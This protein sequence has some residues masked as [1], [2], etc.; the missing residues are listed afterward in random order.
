M[1]ILQ[2]CSGRAVNGAVIHCWALSQRLRALGH[3]VVIAC[4]EQS[5]IR[6]QALAE[7]VPVLETSFR[8]WSLRE[9]RRTASALAAHDIQVMH[10]HQSSAACFGVILRALTGVPSVATAHSRYFQL[11]WMWNDYVIGV[12]DSTTT[13]HRRVNLVAEKRSATVHNFVDVRRFQEPSPSARQRL[14]SEWRVGDDAL[15]FGP[16]GDVIARKGMLYLTRAFPAIL[17]R[18]PQAR[19]LC[20]GGPGPDPAYQRRVQAE[21][22]RLG[23]S[24]KIIWAGK[25]ADIAD[26]LAAMDVFVLPSVEECFPLSILEAMACGLPCVASNVGGVA[27]CIDDR[28]TGILTQPKSPE[29]LS[30][31]INHLLEDEYTRRRFGAAGRK[32]V[33]ERFSPAS[34]APKIAS[35]L[36]RV[37]FTRTAR[38]ARAA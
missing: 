28:R 16:I 22:D 2:L 11:H 12:S 23:V 7:G 10:A 15:L 20:V 25:R 13:F 21:A 9:L 3:Q 38:R 31:A 14:R 30:A 5:W 26:V 19:L 35:I 33:A 18:H 34:Q 6:E 37:V 4:R 17:A 8:K 24:D 1:N 32:R 29:S 27:E 36:E